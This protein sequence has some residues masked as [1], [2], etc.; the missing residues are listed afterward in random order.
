MIKRIIFFVLIININTFALASI[1]DEIILNFKKIDNLS[2][3]LNKLLIKK[4]R[5]E[6]VLFNIQRKFIVVMIIIKKKS[7]FQMED[8]L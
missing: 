1:K 8:R 6:I 7:L 5:K 4:L 3:I 2:L